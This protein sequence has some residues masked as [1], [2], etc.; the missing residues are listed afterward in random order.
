MAT[1]LITIGGTYGEILFNYVDSGS[2][3]HS[4]VSGPGIFYLDDTGSDYKYTVLY[5]DVTASSSCITLVNSPFTCYLIYWEDTPL[6]SLKSQYDIQSLIVGSTEYNLYSIT[7]GAPLKAGNVAFAINELGYPSVSSPA[8]KD[9][10]YL[11]VRTLNGD[12]PYLKL[13]NK[14]ILFDIYLKGQAVD[15]CVPTGY[16]QLNVWPVIPA[17]TTT[18]STTS[19]TSTTTSTSSTT[20]TTIAL[21]I[22]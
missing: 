4:I 22:P 6:C 10:V 7:A 14:Q 21:P 12:V 15:D 8:I 3:S 16:T 19:T 18:T 17:T 13:S 9:S 1:C 20:T 11:I 2:V 5:G